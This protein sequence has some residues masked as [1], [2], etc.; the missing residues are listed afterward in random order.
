MV[1]N[2]KGEKCMFFGR[3]RD[4]DELRAAIDVLKRDNLV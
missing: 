4:V 3:K 2:A 1:E